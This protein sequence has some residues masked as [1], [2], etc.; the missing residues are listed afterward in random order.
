MKIILKLLLDS[1]QL[2]W[3]DYY[4]I[5]WS[6]ILFKHIGLTWREESMVEYT[7]CHWLYCSFRSLSCSQLFSGIKVPVS[8]LWLPPL[9]NRIL[10]FWSIISL[11]QKM[12][13]QIEG[14][15][16]TAL[17]WGSGEGLTEEKG[18]AAKLGLQQVPSLFN[19]YLQSLPSYYSELFGSE[20]GPCSPGLGHS[21]S[22]CQLNKQ[23]IVK[24]EKGDLLKVHIIFIMWPLWI[25]DKEVQRL[26]KSI[27][28]S[29]T[30][31]VGV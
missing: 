19:S 6:N 20:P 4:C 26:S 21:S 17:W 3:K 12:S 28:K 30:W 15:W 5:W 10:E 8:D 31:G 11:Q 27:L 9:P 24:A 23:V 25:R 14:E 7:E 2:N 18:Q 29:L 16:E 13:S 1:H 22:K